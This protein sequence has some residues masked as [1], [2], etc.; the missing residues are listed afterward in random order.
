ML[1][2]SVPAF[3]SGGSATVTA[4]VEHPRT[5]TESYSGKGNVTVSTPGPLHDGDIVVFTL[6]PDKGYRVSAAYYNGQDVTA[7]LV[8]NTFT[9]TVAGDMDFRVTF[10][11]KHPGGD[12]GDTSGE[13]GG[14]T[15][16]GSETGDM[17]VTL[18]A[19]S[20]LLSAA[21]AGALLRRKK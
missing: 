19:A 17:G 16:G 10:A 9:T 7:Q 6:T 8:N 13:I 18:Y 15:V 12:S 20:A 4:K 21:G 14:K 2:L 1:A 3:A 5:M 11:R